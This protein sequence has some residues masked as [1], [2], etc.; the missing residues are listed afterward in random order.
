MTDSHVN[1]LN[2]VKLNLT[3]MPWQD[4]LP[5]MFVPMVILEISSLVGAPLPGVYIALIWLILIAII[6]YIIKHI[7]SMFAIITFLM[8]LT[9]FIAGFL[10]PKHLFF[11]L[12]PSL[13]N[14]LVGLIFIGSMLRPRPF[15]MSLIG[16]E[17]IKRTEAKYGKSKYFFKAWFDINIVWGIFYIFQGILI[18]YTMIL[19]MGTGR[20]LDF[21]LGWPAVMILLY[22]SVDYPRWYWSKNWEKMKI[23]IEAAQEYENRKVSLSSS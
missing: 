13:D 8:I 12:I 18:S 14:T 11:T 5:C 16:K 4:F 21:I 1:G 22:F 20:L 15:I 7:V 3:R 19:H 2:I 6:I 10:E 17:T 9:Q 23:E